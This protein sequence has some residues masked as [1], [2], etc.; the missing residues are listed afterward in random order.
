MDTIYSLLKRAKELK[1]KSQVDSITPEEVGK[2]HED[3]LAY[4]A[5]LEQS[6]DGLGIKKVYQS[7]SAME[8]DTDPVG[9]NGR[10][11]RYGQLVSIYDDAHADSSEN[12]NIYAYQKPGWLLMGKVSGGTTLSIAQE[13]GDSATKVMSQKAVTNSIHDSINGIDA[14]W[15]DDVEIE[16]ISQ[17]NSLLKN[18]GSMVSNNSFV[19]KEFPLPTYKDGLFLK[20]TGSPLGVYGNDGYCGICVYDTNGTFITQ[21][22]SNSYTRIGEKWSQVKVCAS[23]TNINSISVAYNTAKYPTSDEELLGVRYRKVKLQEVVGDISSSE[24]T[25]A[26]VSDFLV[27]PV[28]YELGGI[29]KSFNGGSKLDRRIGI[30]YVDDVNGG[31]PTLQ[32]VYQATDTDIVI[33]RGCSVG[34]FFDGVAP[35]Y[36]TKVATKYRILGKRGY[37]YGDMT[38]NLNVHFDIE[39]YKKL[40][41]VSS[42]K[43]NASNTIPLHWCSVGTSISARNNNMLGYQTNVRSVLNFSKF[44]NNAVSGSFAKDGVS[45]I[46]KADVY[47][48]EEGINDWWAGSLGTFDDYKNKTG[49]GFYGAMRSIIDKVYEVNP[50]AIIILI[51]FAKAKSGSQDWDGRYN[52]TGAYQEDFANAMIEIGKYESL[53]VCDWF[54]LCNINKHNISTL[55]EDGLHPTEEGYKRMAS[56]LLDV[57]KATLHTFSI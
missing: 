53:P 57:M 49:K 8:A 39:S 46:V 11:L 13:A 44:T 27:F 20:I 26:E 37:A 32:S 4:I 40:P 16:G 54:H 43:D 10:A 12:G 47:T 48:I 15:S 5:S 51:N 36:A 45:Q 18:D 23:T 25:A 28:K 34:F 24:G 2:L 50:K 33:P 42:D 52:G 29:I 31:C 6:A 22:K 19:I 38:L 17:L 9:T 21:V 14:I 30:F 35:K 55:M 1:E 41:I 7:K 56:I 3:T